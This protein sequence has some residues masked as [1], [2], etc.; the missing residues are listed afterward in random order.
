MYLFLLIKIT[1]SK[2]YTI[3]VLPVLLA[4]L[5]LLGLTSAYC[6]AVWYA[7]GIWSIYFHQS[8]EM[9]LPLITQ[10]TIA[11][12]PLPL[13]WNM[14][15]WQAPAILSFFLCFIWGIMRNRKLREGQGHA[16]PMTVHISWVIF[17]FFCHLLGI[18]SPMLS[19]SPI[20][21]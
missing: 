19:I 11:P 2:G 15:H 20:A 13:W 1:L 5:I 9:Q 7:S 6:A 17:A 21:G 16:L 10:I 14:I 12:L 4:Y 18:L 3:M 8:A